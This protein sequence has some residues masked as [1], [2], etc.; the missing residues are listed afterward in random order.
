MAKNKPTNSTARSL[1]WAWVEIFNLRI[2]A[3]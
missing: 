2:S 3:L 1:V